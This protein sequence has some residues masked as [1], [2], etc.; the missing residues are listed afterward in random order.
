ML[1]QDSYGCDLMLSSPV[2]LI[3]CFQVHYWGSLVNTEAKYFVNFV[4]GVGHCF[5][6]FIFFGNELLLSPATFHTT[7]ILF[8]IIFEKV[9]WPSIP[10]D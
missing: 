7:V 1:S 5:R 3:R 10:I 8:L 6:Y 4:D 2:M 9:D